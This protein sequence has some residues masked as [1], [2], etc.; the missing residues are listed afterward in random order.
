MTE[1]FPIDPQAFALA[2]ELR[3]I[4]TILADC[5]VSSEGAARALP[6]ARELR[7]AIEAP[8]RRRWYD[9]DPSSPMVG[10]LRLS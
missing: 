9:Q 5:E 10:E 4:A 3:E 1:E 7:A 6:L 8:R 2:N